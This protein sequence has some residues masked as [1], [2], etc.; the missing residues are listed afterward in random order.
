MAGPLIECVPNF[1]EGR[2]RGIVEKIVS[3]I[4]SAPGA[5]LLAWEHDEDHNRAVVTFAGPPDAVVEGAV[6]GVEQAVKLIDLRRHS[7]AHPRI[8][9]A[10]VAPFVPVRGVTLEE[11]AAIARRAGGEI[12]RRLGVPVYF[13]EAAALH[14]GRRNLADVRRGGFE[15]LREAVRANP[16]RRPDV[17]GP[18]LHPTA[19]AVAVGARRFLIAYNINLASQDVRVAR[20]IAGRIRESSGGFPH[21]KALGLELPSRKT[22]QVSM[23]LTNFEET[24]VE[25]VFEAVEDEARRNGTAAA[26]SEI[27]G[28]IPRRAFELAPEFYRRAA[29]FTPQ[30]ILE[31]R[32]AA[33]ESK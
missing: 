14:P 33:L 31:N 12:W 16:E 7:G 26:S 19:G 23:N 10:D 9:A 27:I 1:S 18:E 6:R 13:Y 30:T 4:S 28:L 25:R 21:V 20:R 24:P 3:A 5:V 2:D 8:G 17:G 32:L 22:V 11:C 29:N 15:G